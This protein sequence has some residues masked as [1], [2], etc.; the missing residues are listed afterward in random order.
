[1]QLVFRTEAAEDVATARR[2][3]DRQRSGLGYDFE[4]RLEEL[5]SLI[6]EMPEAFPIVH[7]DLRRALMRRFPYAVYY[8]QIDDDRLEIIACLHSRRSSVRWRTRR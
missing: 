3:Y 2:W 6:L 5:T 8:R 7:A 4:Q 1:M